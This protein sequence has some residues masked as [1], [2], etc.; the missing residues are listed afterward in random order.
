MAKPKRPQN[1]VIVAVTAA[2]ILGLAVC[3]F[4]VRGAGS[5]RLPALIQPVKS[6]TPGPTLPLPQ[7][8]PRGK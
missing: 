2:A 6:P 4:A 5:L 7:R 3:A 1:V 8:P